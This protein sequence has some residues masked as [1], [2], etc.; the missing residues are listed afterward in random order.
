MDHPHPSTEAPAFTAQA[1]DDLADE[2][3]RQRDLEA[4]ARANWVAAEA[5]LPAN[6]P[7]DITKGWI[8]DRWGYVIT[9][10]EGAPIDITIR[11]P[12]VP[13]EINV[14]TK[15]DLCTGY[16]NYEL[17]C[18]PQDIG[19]SQRMLLGSFVRFTR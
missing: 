3:R 9:M 8:G 17:S 12:A 11:T 13:C 16:L 18:M 19:V 10:P 5:R 6:P 7:L 15:P 1:S 2:R 14:G 4:A